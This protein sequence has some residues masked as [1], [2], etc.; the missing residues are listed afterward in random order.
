MS[1]SISQTFVEEKTAPAP[2]VGNRRFGIL[3]LIFMVTVINYADRSTMSIAGTSVS[4]D[5]G[6]GSITI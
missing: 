6:L 1:Q 5:L 3:A 2:R 4:S